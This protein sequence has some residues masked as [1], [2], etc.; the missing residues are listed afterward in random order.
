ME[1]NNTNSLKLDNINYYCI[2]MDVLKNA[3]FIVMGAIAVALIAKVAVNEQ[4]YELTYTTTATFVVSSKGNDNNVYNNLSSAQ[5]TASTLTNILN[6]SIMKKKVQQDLGLA[7]LNME[8]SASV[9]AETNLLTLTVTADSPQLAYKSIRSIMNN[10]SSLSESV[11]GNNILEV[12]KEPQ[13]PLSSD[14]YVANGDEE[15]KR[16]FYYGLIGFAVLFA[17]LSYFHDT[18]K[19][20]SDLSDKLDARALGTIY[21]ERK[22]KTI[23]SRIQHK[24][25][26]IL[27]TN[28]SASFGFVES[29]KKIATKLSY[30]GRKE[31]A[32]TIVVTSILENEGKSTVAANLALSL[33]NEATKVLLIDCDLR[34]PSQYLIFGKREETEEAL[35]L[36]DLLT[37][38]SQ[39]KDKIPFDEK[40]G[41]YLLLTTKP[42]QNSTELL[43]GVQI[44]EILKDLKSQFDYIILDSPPMSLMADAEVLADQADSSV[45]VVKYNQVL[46]KDINDAL[47][48]LGNCRAEVAGCILNQAKRMSMILPSSTGHGYGY[49]YSHYGHYGYGKYGRTEKRDE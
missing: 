33:A 35:E 11:L 16:F 8:A 39:T 20:E 19:S 32:K 25:S 41:I 6:S 18:I 40:L 10:Y 46:A 13:V 38:Y 5:I 24:K 26:S 14:T 22:Y 23:L 43:S 12:L 36:V 28:A 31:T 21:Y 42:Y 9:I 34:K 15:A 27:V 29:Y 47:D 3:L 45:L 49:G 30:L 37:N 1:D 4:Q 44:R 7:N 48:E 2:F 17:L